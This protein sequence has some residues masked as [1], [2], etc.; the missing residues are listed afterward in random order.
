MENK[1]NKILFN[2]AYNPETNPIELV[3]GKIKKYVEKS[4]T[5][6]I[7]QLL[8]SINKAIKTISPNDLRNY[9]FH[10]FLKK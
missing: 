2:V 7:K 9:Y 6:T 10:S 4:P 1:T 5:Q 8:S 3:F